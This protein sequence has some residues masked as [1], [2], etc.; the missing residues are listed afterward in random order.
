[1]LVDD[2]CFSSL[3]RYAPS[4]ALFPYTTLFRSY[5]ADCWDW[6]FPGPWLRRHLSGLHSARPVSPC[7]FSRANGS[8][9]LMPLSLPLFTRSTP[10][11]KSTRLN[12]SHVAISYAVF[13]SK[14]KTTSL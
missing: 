9:Q 14:T 13:C 6:Y 4:D 11:R 10:D 7:S 3:R 8:H 5:W 2:L 12:S 1:V